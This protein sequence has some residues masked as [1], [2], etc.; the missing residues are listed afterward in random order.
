MQ[1]ASADGN[2]KQ[3]LSASMES[4]LDVGKRKI[5]KKISKSL[6]KKWSVLS[7]FG[8]GAFVA[9]AYFMS[10]QTGLAGSSSLGNAIKNS[11][12]LHENGFLDVGDDSIKT[13]ETR[14]NNL[15]GYRFY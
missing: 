15:Y 12:N 7:V 6:P 10:R 13:F 3:P 9:G 2:P 5:K 1:P 4:L 14:T 11:S 8:L